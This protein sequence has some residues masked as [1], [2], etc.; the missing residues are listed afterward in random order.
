ME[1]LIKDYFKDKELTIEN[2]IEMCK[3]Y[4]MLR[5]KINRD[6]D[7]E[8]HKEDII[9]E[10]TQREIEFSDADVECILYKYEDYLSESDEWR[11]ALDC[12]IDW[13]ED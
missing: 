6:V 5:L 4:G 12:A 10:L 13:W 9:D 1:N 7:K 3:N 2:V 11:I 8:Y